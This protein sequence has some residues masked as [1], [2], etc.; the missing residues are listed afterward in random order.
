MQLFVAILVS[1]AIFAGQGTLS[2]LLP[3]AWEGVAELKAILNEKELA[4]YLDSGDI[5]QEV[6]KTEEGWLITTNRSYIAVRIIPL[7]QMQPGPEKFK[8]EFK[9]DARPELAQFPR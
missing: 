6:S 7:P 3:P 1:I 8:L 4:N 2:A 9:R 5:L